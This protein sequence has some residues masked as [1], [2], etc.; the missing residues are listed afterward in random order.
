VQEN[1]AVVHATRI[2]PE[3]GP[4]DRRRLAAAG[5]SALLPG[6]GQLFN[7]RPRLA[8]LFLIP[9][10]VLILVALF[11]FN[12]QSTARLVAWII[13]PQVMGTLLSLNLVLLGWRLLAVVQAFLDT[14]RQ[15]PTGRL[16]IIGLVVIVVLVTIPHL[17]VWRYG[18]LLGDTFAQVFT[19]QVLGDA[20]GPKVSPGPVP[21]DGQR[22]NVLLIGID[23]TRK[24]T[25]TLTDTM[26]VASLDPVGKTVSLLS[27]PRDLID[28]PL[29]GGDVYGPKLNSLLA[30]A[31]SH[32]DVFPQ[33]GIRAL[34][35]A[36]GTLL[37][38][39]IHYYAQIDF[40]GLIEM[41][42][43]VHGVDVDVARGFD[44]PTYDGYGFEGRG[45]SITAGPHHLDGANALAF[46]RSRKAAGESD[47][48]R[49]ARQQQILVALRDKVTSGGSVL[50]ALPDLLAAVGKTIHSNVPVDQLPEFAAIM[51]EMGKGAVTST[52][53]HF[54]LVHPIS[55]RFGDS[56][57]GDIPAIRAVAAALFPTPGTAPVPW[58]TPRPTKAPKATPSP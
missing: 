40:S 21:G 45:W 52:V 6:L 34:E 3:T 58:P 42:D 39:P 16:G 17:A 33:G 13:S 32:K 49:A 48:T 50:F 25:A 30:Y 4:L 12:T 55:T 22:I 1:A 53:I 38:I 26:M 29:P 14:S 8:A 10:L 36:I 2:R 20:G 31:D 47:F 15:G 27:V 9:S 44:D 28:T 41:V 56:Q 35:G 7:R 46:A 43:A 24:R 5:L 23:K 37:G 54:P 18:S 11:M 19:S 57:Q 51:D